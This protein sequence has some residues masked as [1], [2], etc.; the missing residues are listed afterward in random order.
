MSFALM[1]LDERGDRKGN[2]RCCSLAAQDDLT[3]FTKMGREA[4]CGQGTTDFSDWCSSEESSGSSIILYPLSR[5]LV[6]MIFT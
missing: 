5:R 1:K 6:L 2:I 3:G 4:V